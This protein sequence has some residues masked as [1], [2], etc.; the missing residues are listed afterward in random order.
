MFGTVF[1][2]KDTNHITYLNI[3]NINDM[4]KI[5]RSRGAR[6][7]TLYKKV[8]VLRSLVLPKIAH[9]LCHASM[10]IVLS[11]FWHGKTPRLSK[12]NIEADIKED[13]LK[14]YYT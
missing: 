3:G 7:L 11:C 4:T 8:T 10:M 12:K 5:I 13:G 1:E 6:S 9:L 14:L 2:S